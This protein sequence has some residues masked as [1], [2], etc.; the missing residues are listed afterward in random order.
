MDNTMSAKRSFKQLSPN[1]NKVEVGLNYNSLETSSSKNMQSLF[2]FSTAFNNSKPFLP[3]ASLNFPNREA[4]WLGEM[5]KQ[6]DSNCTND[7]KANERVSSWLSAVSSTISN[8]A[9]APEDNDVEDNTS[10]VK[11]EILRIKV[12]ENWA[13]Y[14]VYL[15]FF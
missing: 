8:I 9:A 4:S 15:W 7:M 6:H 12:E 13:K 2:N 3:P 11:G 14:L 5:N 10:R 1:N